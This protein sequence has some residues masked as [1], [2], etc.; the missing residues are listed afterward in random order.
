MR[1]QMTF[2]DPTKCQAPQHRELLLA[3]FEIRSTVGNS[4]KLLALERLELLC[5]ELLRTTAWI[6]AVGE[7]FTSLPHLSDEAIERFAFP[8]A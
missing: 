8:L 5:L 7:S 4:I 6:A 1:V 2:Y 3:E